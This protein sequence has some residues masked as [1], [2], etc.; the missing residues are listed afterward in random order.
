MSR[1]GAGSGV[2]CPRGCVQVQR[3]RTYSAEEDDVEATSVQVGCDLAASISSSSLPCCLRSC[4]SHATRALLSS[5]ALVLQLPSTSLSRSSHELC[6]ASRKPRAVPPSPVLSI[7]PHE[8][9]T[10]SLM[11]TSDS[12][13]PTVTP[14]SEWTQL[15]ARNCGNWCAQPCSDRHVRKDVKIQIRENL[16][17]SYNNIQRREI[18]DEKRA[19]RVESGS[20]HRLGGDVDDHDNGLATCDSKC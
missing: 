20:T 3:G 15:M 7:S 19:K 11:N 14:K 13:I 17:T 1:R 8:V 12:A 9:A 2:G 16:H 6:R 4:S 5:S 18:H 10:T